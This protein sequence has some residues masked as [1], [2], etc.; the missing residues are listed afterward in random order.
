MNTQLE[1]VLKHWIRERGPITFAEF[2]EVA[3]YDRDHGYYA[4]GNRISE[5]GDFF[6]SPSAHPA[7][8]ALLAVQLHEFWQHLGRPV[9]FVVVEPGA[10]E[11]LLAADITGYAPRLDPEFAHAMSYMAFDVA[12]ASDSAYPVQP[13]SELP[14]GVTGCVVSNELLD[15]MPVHRFVIQDGSVRELFVD[16]QG[17]DLVEVAGPP[18]TPLIE[19]R[20]GTLPASLPNGYR[21]E[22]NPGIDQWAHMVRRVLA[23]GYV[24]TVDYGYDRPMLYAPS[25][26]EGTLRCYYRH[27]LGQA[28]LRNVGE[29]DITTHVDFTALD[30]AMA[31]SGFESAGHAMQ[32]EFLA[33]LGAREM[34]RNLRRARLP[35]AEADTNRMAMLELLKPEGMGNFRVV[36]HRR[37][38]PALHIT[39]LHGPEDGVPPDELPVPLISNSGRHISLFRGRYPEAARMAG[40]TWEDMFGSER[41]E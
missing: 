31:G 40:T 36:I 26:W 28:P 11:G 33:N 24:L 7:F 5:G 2:M 17:E 22:V 29:Q 3:L 20:L 37:G 34:I 14:S 23:H 8:G 6:T 19:Q 9:P 18:S 10:A 25:R 16:V 35:Q 27:T 21:G 32:S 38:V 41:R 13:I 4:A 15:A 39:G 1:M 12:P 30:E